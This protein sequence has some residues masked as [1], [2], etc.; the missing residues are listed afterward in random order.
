MDE[1]EILGKIAYEAYE[2]AYSWVRRGLLG[3]DKLREDEKQPWIA[4]GQAVA[5]RVIAD[6]QTAVEASE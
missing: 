3:W 1:H 5:E 6:L 4:V 2:Q